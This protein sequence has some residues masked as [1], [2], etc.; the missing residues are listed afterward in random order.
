[1]SKL[2]CADFLRLRKSRLFWACFIVMMV[3][4]GVY[5]FSF[6]ND[7]IKYDADVEFDDILFCFAFAV[8]FVSSVFCS[9]FIGTE[10]S[11]RTLHNKLIVGHSRTAIYFSALIS[12][13]TATVAVCLA[14]VAVV[15]IFGI[16]MFGGLHMSALNM[17][18]LI[19]SSFLLITVYCSV[20]TLIAMLCSNRALSSEIC[21][22][23]V[24][25][26]FIAALQLYNRISAP[27][28]YEGVIYSTDS[29]LMESERIDNP[30][31]ISGAVRTVYE[32]VF[33]FLPT[34]QASQIAGMAQMSN[35]MR[36]SLFSFIVTAIF[37]VCGAAV[38]Y[39]KD[40]K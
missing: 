15:C 10:Y 3:I 9:L 25:V 39:R 20:F 28:Y 6:Y 40:I 7:M 8:G 13:I 21:I 23:S 17:W 18:Q 14:C 26:M 24:V 27:E 32:T 5:V 34:G 31:Y 22:L 36:L 35:P 2:I 4:G 30:R 38:F 37:T 33:D 29:G 12:N 1:M 19:L 11:D 16:P